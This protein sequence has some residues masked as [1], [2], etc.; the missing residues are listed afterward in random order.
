MNL[1]DFRAA[2]WAMP[3]EQR[4]KLA[5]QYLDWHDTLPWEIEKRTPP[6]ISSCIR[7]SP[8]PREHYDNILRAFLT[9]V[10]TQRLLG[11]SS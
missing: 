2:Y 5:S 8:G 6:S 10:A 7:A 4:D 9:H 11:E 1:E 3:R